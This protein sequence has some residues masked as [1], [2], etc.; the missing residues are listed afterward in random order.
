MKPSSMLLS[1]GFFV[2]DSSGLLK[3]R[4]EKIG[5]DTPD[6]ERSPRLMHPYYYHTPTSGSLLGGDRAPGVPDGCNSTEFP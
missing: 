4:R 1:L 6:Y 5:D 3:F 2:Q